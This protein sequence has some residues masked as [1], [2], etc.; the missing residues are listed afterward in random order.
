MT[1]ARA[2]WPRRRPN[3]CNFSSKS[4]VILEDAYVIETLAWCSC[5]GRGGPAAAG[6]RG[7]QRRPTGPTGAARRGPAPRPKPGCPRSGPRPARTS[8]GA[9]RSA[10]G[11]HRSSSVT[12]STCRPPSGEGATLQERVICFNADTGKQLWE[13]RYNLF[14]SD[15]PA[16]SHRLVLAGRRH[17]D[18]QRVRDQRRRPADVAVAGRQAALGT[19]ARR[20]VRHV[21]DARRAHVVADH[22]RRP[23]DRQRAHVHV[24]RRRPTART[25]SCRSTRRAAARTTSARP[26]A[27]RPTRSTPTPFIAD[28][29]G[30]RTFF[31]GGSDGA[32]HA[33]KVNTG[34]KIWSWRSASAVSTPPRSAI[35]QDIIVTHS[36]ENVGS[37]E[38]GMVAAVPMASK[39]E[40]A[41]KD[42]RWLTR[43]VQAGYASPVTDGERIYLLDNGGVLIAVDLKTGKPVWRE[44]ARHDRQGL[45]GLRRRQALHRHREHRRRRR[46]VLHHPSD[47]REGGDPRPGLARHAAEIRADHRLTDRRARPRLRDVDGR[48]LRDRPQ[49]D[50]EAG[51]RRRRRRPSRSHRSAAGPATTAPRDPDR[52][53]VKPGESLALSGEAVRR[54]RQSRRRAAPTRPG[55]SRT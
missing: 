13:H 44:T 23:G 17:R 22:R 39:G 32:M 8:P 45:A 30:V 14:T 51:A 52:L 41:D 54:Q 35:G 2:D 10:A 16:A 5:V 20:R 53:I 7:S 29:N 4:G 3:R 24:G 42:A 28:V 25:A 12:A 21:D 43:G 49:G 26:K 34:E 47:R 37:S 38:M 40:L 15:A 55:R 11:R 6:H 46:Q 18:R 50:A 36:E 31:S 33:I 48:A 9:C 19:L 27:G 1:T